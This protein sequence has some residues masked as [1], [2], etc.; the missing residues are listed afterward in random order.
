MSLV[1]GRLP[2]GVL[3]ANQVSAQGQRGFD[4]PLKAEAEPSLGYRTVAGMLGF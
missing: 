2:H 4:R 3:P 1:W